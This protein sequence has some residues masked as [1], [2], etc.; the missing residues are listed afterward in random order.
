MVRGGHSVKV[1]F[2]H[3]AERNDG[4]SHVG[5]WEERISS[6]GRSRCKCLEADYLLGLFENNKKV[7]TA[8]QRE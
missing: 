3:K 6:R 4:M 5:I 2:G 7:S 1:T 8:D